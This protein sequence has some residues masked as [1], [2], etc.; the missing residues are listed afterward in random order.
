M[1]QNASP[2]YTSTIGVVVTVSWVVTQTQSGYTKTMIVNYIREH[3]VRVALGAIVI[4]LATIIAFVFRG[5]TRT[6]TGIDHVFGN[7]NVRLGETLT[8]ADD[9][10]VRATNDIT[11]AGLVSCEGGSA[12]FVAGGKITVSGTLLCLRDTKEAGAEDPGLGILLVAK[13]GIEFTDDAEVITNGHIGIVMDESRLLETKDEIA[14][15]FAEA[16]ENRGGAA[17]IGPMTEQGG[18]RTTPSPLSDGMVPEG[19]NFNAPS[20]ILRGIW[21]MADETLVQIP[22]GGQIPPPVDANGMLFFVDGGEHAV[23]LEHLQIFGA[24][25]RN[26]KDETAICNAEGGQAVSGGRIQIN[27]GIVAIKDTVLVLG[28]GG[29]G[30]DAVTKTD[31]AP[32]VARGGNG[33]V[34]GNFKVVAKTAIT[35]DALRIIPGMGGA[36]GSA[37]AYGRNGETNCPGEDGGNAEAEGGHGGANFAKITAVGPIDGINRI[38]IDRAIAGRGGSAVARP[39]EG[40]KGATCECSGGRGGNG[41]A[42]GGK[43]GDAATAVPN[44]TGEAHGGDGGNSETRGGAGGAGGKCETLAAGGTGG[45]GGS[46]D[47][48]AGWGGSG[49]TAPGRDGLLLP[50]IGGSGGDGGNGCPAGQAGKGGRGAPNGKDGGEG[51]STCVRSPY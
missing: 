19:A 39:G 14:R 15:A 36:G 50:R 48:S 27:A 29:K 3:R 4:L 22:N 6:V 21:H 13:D 46:A 33:G 30:G 25:G 49:T 10:A 26:G 35:I 20:I 11:I 18:A 24:N 40:G 44:V 38:M 42:V 1:A 43:G 47:G 37:I 5:G 51:R 17:R 34:P 9:G 7:F 2:L 32:G 8:M 12:L 28:K 31:C 23:V 16:G 45:G 41:S